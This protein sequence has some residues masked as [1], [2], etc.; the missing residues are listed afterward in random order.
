MKDPFRFPPVHIAEQGDH[1]PADD[2]AKGK[3]HNDRDHQAVNNFDPFRT[4]D[5]LQAAVK[6][7]GASSQ[8]GDQ[9][10]AL[11]G[12]NSEIPCRRRPYHDREQGRA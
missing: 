10:V 12:R 8:S 3:A 9:R 5:A 11:A 1:Q 6:S 7:D 4:V 2:P